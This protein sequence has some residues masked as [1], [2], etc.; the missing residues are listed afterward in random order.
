M[1]KETR[2]IMGMPIVLMTPDESL[3]NENIEEVFS[4]FRHVDETYSPFIE[5]SIVSR[6]NRGGVGEPEYTD[7][8]REILAIAK[9]KAANEWI[10]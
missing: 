3:T 7:E 9:S 5:S 1:I 4:F 6:I 10:F 2:Q 8:L